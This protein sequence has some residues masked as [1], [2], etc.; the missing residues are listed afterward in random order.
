MLILFICY[1]FFI[2]CLCFN[3]YQR[4]LC[5]V[6]FIHFQ[7]GNICF[8]FPANTNFY[9][10]RCI[11]LR[12]FRFFCDFAC[13]YAVLLRYCFLCFVL[14]VV[15]CTYLDLLLY[16][17]LLFIF[18]HCLSSFTIY[19]HLIF[20]FIHHLSPCIPHLHIDLEYSRFHQSV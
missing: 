16:L 18:I 1:L 19:L 3:C 20:I 5:Y 11:C 10:P 2:C 9:F 4:F 14:I 12:Y 8:Q 7:L 17:H 6:I 13:L 15:A